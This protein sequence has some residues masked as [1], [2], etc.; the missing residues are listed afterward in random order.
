MLRILAAL[1]VSFMTLSS[2][3][4]ASVRVRQECGFSFAVC[5]EVMTLEQ[6]GATYEYLVPGPVAPLRYSLAYLDDEFVMTA[7]GDNPLGG[8]LPFGLAVYPGSGPMLTLA[9]PDSTAYGFIP[10][11]AFPRGEGT[12]RTLA[13]PAMEVPEPQTGLLLLAGL[14]AFGWRRKL[15]A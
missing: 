9:F 12:M 14:A 15:K 10:M 11:N 2:S 5:G 3:H 8:S 13:I 4:A 1:L 7:L 6:N